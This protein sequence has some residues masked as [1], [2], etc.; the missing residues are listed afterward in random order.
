[1]TDYDT[2]GNF[3]PGVPLSALW[4]VL[5]RGDDRGLVALVGESPRVQEFLR[6]LDLSPRPPSGGAPDQ[7][8]VTV[9]G[10]WPYERA[11][12][13]VRQIHTPETTPAQWARIANREALPDPQRVVLGYL[14]GEVVEELLHHF[15]HWREQAELD[16]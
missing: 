10:E 15:A 2:A 7:A 6:H 1:M 4:V 3:R 14:D 9:L 12:D 8:M 16:G 13:L 5:P 11:C